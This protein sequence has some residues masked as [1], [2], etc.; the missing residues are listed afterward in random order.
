MTTMAAQQTTW[1][2]FRGE[3]QADV[4]A[5]VSEQ[6]A[7]LSWT[8]EQVEAAQRDGLRKLLAHAAKHSPFHR[9]RLGG[10][11]PHEAEIADLAGLPVMTKAE[12]MASFD[13]VVTDRGVSLG[14]VEAALGETQAEPVPFLGQYVAHATGGSSGQRGVFVFD[15]AAKAGFVLSIMRGLM[16]RLA[17]SEGPPPGQLTFA[18]VA[19]ASAVHPTAAAAAETSG[20]GMPVRIISVPVTLPWAELTARLTSIRPHIL[21]GYPSVLMRL[22]AEQQAG[23]LKLAPTMIVSTSETLLAHVRDALTS[24]F[25]APVVDTFACT[26]GLVGAGDPGGTVLSF[27][28]DLCIAE[29][30]DEDNKPV[31]PGVPSAKVLLTNLYNRAQ[32]LI[33]YELPDIFVAEPGSGHARLR[34]RVQGRADEVLGYPGVTLHPHVIRSVLVRTPQIADYQVRQTESGIDLDVLDAGPPGIAEPIAADDLTRRLTAAL[35]RA[36]LGDPQ[37]HVRVVSD[38]T[39]QQQS[40]K[41]SRFVP[42]P[43]R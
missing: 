8:R 32:P 35:G 10:L 3:L 28:S 38:L 25:G 15:R 22:A 23:R 12:M 2:R 1:E 30:V 26:E 4:M 13:D 5:Q 20:S 7:R 40:G 27:N 37:V 16:A 19:A 29:L 33:R 18:M 34:A 36:G 41:L 24:T 21:G 39:R 6:V 11:I 43:G 14:L 31:R 9:A 42:L 17:A